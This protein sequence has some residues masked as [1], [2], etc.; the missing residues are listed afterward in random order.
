MAG[1]L[2][3][4]FSPRAFF[5]RFFGGANRK[6]DKTAFRFITAKSGFSCLRPSLLVMATHLYG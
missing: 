2:F 4:V 5:T 1:H 3:F 6:A